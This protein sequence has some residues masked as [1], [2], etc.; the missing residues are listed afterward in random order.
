MDTDRQPGIKIDGIVLKESV[1]KR[2][3]QIPDDCPLHM[4]FHIHTTVV[5]NPPSRIVELSCKINDQ[6]SPVYVEVVFVGV[7]SVS[8]EPNMSL[9]QFAKASA[10]AALLPYVREE[11]HNR[12]VKGGLPHFAVL[13]PL[14]V[15][16][17]VNSLE[18]NQAKPRNRTEKARSPR[19][20]KQDRSRK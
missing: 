17:L 11:I 19:A 5:A 7:F 3:A 8:G 2:T 15:Q 12:F 9:D 14:N 4:S 20:K 6:K 1:F 13:P 16:A 18:N 10:P